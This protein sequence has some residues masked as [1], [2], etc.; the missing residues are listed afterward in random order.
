MIGLEPFLE[1]TKTLVPC[2]RQSS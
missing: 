1:Q 2:T